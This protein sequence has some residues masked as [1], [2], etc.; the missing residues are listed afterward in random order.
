MAAILPEN[1][2]LG[3]RESPVQGAAVARSATAGGLYPLSYRLGG[4]ARA[5]MKVLV[6]GG[7]GFIGYHSCGG[8]MGGGEES[9]RFDKL[10]QS[11]AAAGWGLAR[12]GGPAPGFLYGSV[13]H[14]GWGLA[15]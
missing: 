5:S 1:L 8:M 2:D 3:E 15:P 12:H 14:G 4:F 10:W 9:P 7:A 13:S 6:T 11:P